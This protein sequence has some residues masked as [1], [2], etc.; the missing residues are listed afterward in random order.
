MTVAA[1]RDPVVRADAA[2]ALEE[3]SR[4]LA[5]AY[6]FTPAKIWPSGMPASCARP[7]IPRWAIRW[8][9]TEPILRRKLRR[10]DRLIGPASARTATSATDAL[11]DVCDRRSLHLCAIRMIPARFYVQ[12]QVRSAGLCL[13]IRTLCELG[14]D[15]EDLVEA[16]ATADAESLDSANCTIQK[17]RPDASS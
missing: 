3:V 14:P 10:N 1:L 2:G 4:A 12:E 13:A 16:I 5:V 9:A 17:L 6:E 11:P 7:I 8:P 15:E